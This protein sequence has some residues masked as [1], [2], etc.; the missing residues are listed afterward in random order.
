MTDTLWLQAGRAPSVVRDQDHLVRLVAELTSVGQR[1]LLRV[2]FQPS[3]HAVVIRKFGSFV[4]LEIE[5]QRSGRVPRLAP[6][7]IWIAR[8]AETAWSWVHEHPGDTR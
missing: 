1:G 8:A 6:R 3:R 5:S 4:I 2:K 7:T